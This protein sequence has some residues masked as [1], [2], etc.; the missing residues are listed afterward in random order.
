MRS[1]SVV[2]AALLALLP[3]SCAGG[4]ATGFE[5]SQGGSLDLQNIVDPGKLGGMGARYALQEPVQS[6]CEEMQLKACDKLSA[7]IL[8]YAGGDRS[9]GLA[10]V[11]EG[12]AKN[13]SNPQRVKLYVLGVRALEAA[14]AVGGYVATI[15]PVLDVLDQAADQAIRDG[16]NGSGEGVGGGFEVNLP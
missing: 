7:G 9:A 2:F 3:L 13:M 11:Q 10:S 14:P 15:T 8:L 6:K 12:A 1:P 4:T 5:G 16:A